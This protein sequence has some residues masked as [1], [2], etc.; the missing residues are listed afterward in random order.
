MGH[1]SEKKIWKQTKGDYSQSPDK[2]SG[3]DNLA[4]IE[5]K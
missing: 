3:M 5:Y 4:C 1:N 2:Y